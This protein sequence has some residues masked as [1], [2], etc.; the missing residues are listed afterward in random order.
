M[1][2]STTTFINEPRGSIRPLKSSYL[3]IKSQYLLLLLGSLLAGAANVQTATAQATTA[4][5]ANMKTADTLVEF[6]RIDSTLKIGKAGYRVDCRNKSV[7][8]NQLSIKPVGF[9]SGARDVSFTLKGRVAGA[10]IDD[11]NRDGYPDLILFIYSDSSASSGT[12][13]GF[14]SDANKEII[15]CILPDVA[16]N[17]KINTGYKGHDKFS[18]MEGTL[19]QRFPIYKTGDDK[20]KPTGGN[21]VILYQLAKGDRGSYK[22]NMIRFYDTK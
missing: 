3:R 12:V 8:Q 16:M 7:T 1:K 13:Y 5:T 11:L 10:Q 2:P 22:F 17:S 9:E 15:P 19:L 6:P 4:Q 14:I 18:L 21:R 20:G